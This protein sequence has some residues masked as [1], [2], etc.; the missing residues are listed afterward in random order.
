MATTHTAPG[1]RFIEALAAR[2]L[3]GA[4]SLLHAD[5]AFAALMP[6]KSVAKIGVEEVM[7][8]FCGFVVDD[9]VQ[10]VEVLDDHDVAGRR[11]IAYRCRWSTPDDGPHV[12]EQHGF[13]DTSDGQ[14][15]WIHL[16][17][18]G[19]QPIALGS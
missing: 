13:Y 19:D 16:A 6:E 5:V 15:S 2:D 12:F 3:D 10:S 4:R 14:L 11:A 9:C 1:A 18:S 17:C 7:A 8:M